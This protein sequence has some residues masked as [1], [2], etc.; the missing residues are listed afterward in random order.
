M[1]SKCRVSLSGTCTMREIWPSCETFT[2]CSSITKYA[3][4][5]VSVSSP[6]C[7][8]SRRAC[9]R[10]GAVHAAPGAPARRTFTTMSMCWNATPQR[11]HT[12][13]LVFQPSCS[14][15]NFNRDINLNARATTLVIYAPATLTHVNQTRYI[16]TVHDKRSS[17]M[18]GKG[19]RIYISRPPPCR[20]RQHLLSNGTATFKLCCL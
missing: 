2:S 9:G 15:W 10:G 1:P 8:R 19:N 11:S 17:C 7:I 6:H 4:E 14:M 3:L 5:S 13:L 16:R 12:K 18:H 20:H